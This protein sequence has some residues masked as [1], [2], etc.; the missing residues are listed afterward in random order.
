MV[1]ETHDRKINTDAKIHDD[2]VKRLPHERDESPD[3]HDKE[4][5][6]V[7]K[8]AADD[9]AQG[10]VDTDMHGVRGVEEAVPTSG[11]GQARPKAD[12]GSGMRHHEPSD[13]TKGEGNQE[14]KEPA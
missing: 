1:A 2:D 8:Q 4:P 6:G 11:S 12:A 9:L 3:G 5:R 10:L 7:M 13:Q 14:G